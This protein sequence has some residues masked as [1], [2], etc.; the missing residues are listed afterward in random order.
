MRPC[1]PAVLLALLLLVTGSAA[2]AQPSSC[3]TSVRR[4]ELAPGAASPPELCIS[5][6]LSTT[7]LFD[8]PLAKDGVVLEGRERFR[9]VDSAGALLA[10]VPSEQLQPGERLQLKVRF[11]G[12]EA[13]ESASFV[14]A[15]HRDEAER[16][17]EISRAPSGAASCQAELQRKQEELQRCL[18]QAD[19]PSPRSERRA[20]LAELLAEG[21]VDEQLLTSVT[22]NRREL[23]QTSGEGL[24][25]TRATLY[26]SLSRLV[27]LVEV[28]GPDGMSPWR[29]VGATLRGPSGEALQT[30]WVVQRQPLVSGAESKVWVE[31]ELPRGASRGP[32]ILELWEE[33]K[34]RTLTVQGVKLP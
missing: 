24:E 11:A 16:Q 9:R 34:T 23:H 12:A 31:V 25:A 4:I 28:E 8:R 20:S 6:G 22:F 33:G 7:L 14:L 29:A 21:G 19:S 15:V 3:Q 10:L 5:P 13:P 27:T 26:R 1:A 17:V 18:A 2:R 30:L 32:Y